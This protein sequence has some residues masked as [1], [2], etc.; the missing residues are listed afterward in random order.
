MLKTRT[1]GQKLT[2]AAADGPEALHHWINRVV[3]VGE[4]AGLD[5]AGFGYPPWAMQPAPLL[6]KEEGGGE[7]GGGQSPPVLPPA[8]PAVEGGGEVGGAQSTPVLAPAPPPVLPKEEGGGEVG[9]GQTPLELPPE[10]LIKVLGYRFLH[11]DPTATPEVIKAFENRPGH[12]SCE[13][14]CIRS[15]STAAAVVAVVVGTAAAVVAVA[16]VRQ[17]RWTSAGRQRGNSD[18]HQQAGREAGQPAGRQAGRQAGRW[19]SDPTSEFHPGFVGV[20][21]PGARPCAARQRGRVVAPIAGPRFSL[22]GTVGS[23]ASEALV[24]GGVMLKHRKKK[25]EE[26]GR[27]RKKE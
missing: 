3:E 17:F 24:E 14:Q 6:P 12:R 7:V 10:V 22:P 2:I 20:A 18:G 26:G 4:A 13:Q 15:C 8:P 1:A 25:E 5:S 23:A 9:G 11:N 16:A 21:V 27:R 19:R